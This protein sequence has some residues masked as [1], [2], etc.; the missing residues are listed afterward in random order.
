MTFKLFYKS[1]NEKK[2]EREKEKNKKEKKGKMAW[3]DRV[4][5]KTVCLRSPEAREF[6]NKWQKV[7]P[8]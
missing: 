2:K 8:E 5:E 3:L 6:T 4:K 1:G 7:C